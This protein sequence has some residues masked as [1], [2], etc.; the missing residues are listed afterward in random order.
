MKTTVLVNIPVKVSPHKTLTNIKGVIRCKELRSTP[1]EDILENLKDQ[2]VSEVHK[3]VIKKEGNEITTGTII[4]TFHG[5]VIP[6]DIRV[7]Y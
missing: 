1:Q 6:T 3:I 4:L 5:S 7:G 2:G